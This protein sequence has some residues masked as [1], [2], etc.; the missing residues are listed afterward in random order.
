MVKLPFS[1]S[2]CAIFLSLLLQSFPAY[3]GH[4]GDISCDASWGICL[5]SVSLNQAESV[6]NVT[7]IVMNGLSFEM[8]NDALP[9][10]IS[11]ADG[12]VVVT[13][14]GAALLLGQINEPVGSDAQT[15]MSRELLTSPGIDLALTSQ[16]GADIE[17]C[18]TTAL[19][20]V[21]E[22]A[23]YHTQTTQ[24]QIT[25]NGGVMS[26]MQSNQAIEPPYSVTSS[27]FPCANGQ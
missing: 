7:S 9:I 26:S 17:R 12:T 4:R 24:L 27:P 25:Q 8:P 20:F 15:A 11:N 10:T 16:A 18:N 22:R 2:L 23:H 19:G 13:A 6:H 5:Q 21:Y 1:L 3:A 14:N